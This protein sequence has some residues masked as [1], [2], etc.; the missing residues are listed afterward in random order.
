[1]LQIIEAQQIPETQQQ[2]LADLEFHILTEIQIQ[3]TIHIDEVILILQAEEVIVNQVIT[4]QEI[5]VLE[6]VQV[7][8]I[9][10]DLPLPREVVVM[11]D[12][13]HHL[14]EVAV[15]KPLHQEVIHHLDQHPHLQEVVQDV[16]I[17]KKN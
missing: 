9:I 11:L 5:T 6:I 4:E 1:M 13:P 7:I 12:H 10:A 8:E 14:Q 17:D 15:A 3:L 16:Q 2:E